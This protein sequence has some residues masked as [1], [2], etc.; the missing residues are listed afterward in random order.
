MRDPQMQ[1]IM[2]QPMFQDLARQAAQ[3]PSALQNMMRAMG[4][5][6]GAPGAPK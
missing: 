3:D 1:E 2:Q 6:P 4:K 5:G